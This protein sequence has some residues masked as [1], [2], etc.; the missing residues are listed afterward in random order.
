MTALNQNSSFSQIISF[1]NLYQIFD[2]KNNL[3][4][5]YLKNHIDN[6]LSLLFFPSGPRFN[7]ALD[8]MTN[9]NNQVLMDELLNGTAH[10]NDISCIF[11]INDEKRVPLAVLE[12]FMK[13]FMKILIYYRNKQKAINLIMTAKDF[14]LGLVLNMDK[15]CVFRFLS[16]LVSME[17]IEYSSHPKVIGADLGL[18]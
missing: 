5:L 3:L 11:F 1:S 4:S 6:V 18:H 8:L 13:I 17:N 15:E 12:A 2:Q 14:I 9:I 7:L 10:L 16:Y